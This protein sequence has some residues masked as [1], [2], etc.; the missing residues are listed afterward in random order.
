[1]KNVHTETKATLEQ[2]QKNTLI[3]SIAVKLLQKL[4]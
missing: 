1:M 4:R 3:K 2:K